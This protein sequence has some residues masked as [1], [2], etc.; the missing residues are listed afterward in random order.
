MNTSEFD[1]VF[2][3]DIYMDLIVRDIAAA[4]LVMPL[5]L[6][7]GSFDEQALSDYEDFVINIFGRIESLR[8]HVYEYN[9]SRGGTSHYL[10]FLSKTDDNCLIILRISDHSRNVYSKMDRRRNLHDA[11]YYTGSSD[12][13]WEV[14][15]IVVNNRRF[16]TYTDALKYI[17]AKLKELN[18]DAE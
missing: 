11:R 13:F 15:N 9:I 8:F 18:I 14:A 17:T 7:D 2:D 12:A 4:T 1:Y 10:K 3:I 16:T 6:A 5:K